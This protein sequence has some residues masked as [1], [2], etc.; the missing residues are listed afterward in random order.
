MSHL[1]PTRLHSI[2]VA[3]Q[4]V[5]QAAKRN[6]LNQKRFQ[7]CQYMLVRSTEGGRQAL[8]GIMIEHPRLLVNPEVIPRMMGNNYT[9]CGSTMPMAHSRL[10]VVDYWCQSAVPIA[11]TILKSTPSMYTRCT[12]STVNDTMAINVLKNRNAMTQ[13]Q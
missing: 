5:Q 2:E 8:A 7:S 1:C 3:K 9:E 4:E 11:C 12:S 6:G 10:L 13:L